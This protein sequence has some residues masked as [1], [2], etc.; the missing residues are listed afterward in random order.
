MKISKDFERSLF[1]K[2]LMETS[3]AQIQKNK[4]T[5]CQQT[6]PGFKI[7]KKNLLLFTNLTT[8]SALLKKLSDNFSFL[9]P[10]FNKK[11]IIHYKNIIFLKRFIPCGTFSI[12]Q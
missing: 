6:I 8:I 9:F 2:N 12:R 3:L 5:L 1:G 10:D 11:L 7:T 4:I